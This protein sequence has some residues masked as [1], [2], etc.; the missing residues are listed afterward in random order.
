[1]KEILEDIAMRWAFRDI[2]A[3]RHRFIKVSD[4][5]I[6]RFRELG[7][8]GERDGEIYATGYAALS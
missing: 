1:M 6:Q 7:W 5:K 4:A 3:R 2:I 8:I